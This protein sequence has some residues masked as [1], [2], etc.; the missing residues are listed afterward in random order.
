M[1]LAEFRVP[2]DSLIPIGSELLAEKVWRGNQII[3]LAEP[4]R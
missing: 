1:K 3:G 4:A 2:A